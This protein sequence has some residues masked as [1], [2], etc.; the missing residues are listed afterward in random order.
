MAKSIIGDIVALGDGFGGTGT[1]TDPI[2]VDSSEINTSDLNNDAGFITGVTH[3]STITGDG[4]S[5]ASKLSV[6]EMVGSKVMTYAPAV[7][8]GVEYAGHKVGNQLWTGHIAY[9]TTNATWYKNDK[10]TYEAYG[11]Y[12]TF[13][14]VSIINSL[15]TD[16]W[17]VPTGNDINV[18]VNTVGSSNYKKLLSSADNGTD[19][20][21]LGWRL[22]GY[23]SSWM[24]SLARYRSSVSGDVGMIISGSLSYNDNNSGIS[25][26]NIV[27]VKDIVADTDGTKGLVPQPKIA[28]V[29]K[30]LRG[31]G[32]WSAVNVPSKT[33]DLTNDSGFIDSGDIT[34]ITSSQIDS[35]DWSTPVVL[36]PNTLRIQ[37]D[38]PADEWSM[39]GKDVMD[40]VVDAG[41]GSYTVVDE[42]KYIY[43]WTYNNSNWSYVFNGL[44]DYQAPGYKVIAAGDT[45]AVTNTVAMF[46]SGHLRSVCWM[47]LRNVTNMSSMFAKSSISCVLPDFDFDSAE[48][49]DE[50][51]SYVTSALGVVELYNKMSAATTI[52]SH[53]DT[54][55]MCG[56]TEEQAQIPVSWGGTKEEG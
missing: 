11:M 3:D 35:L 6:K 34:E 21:G 49:V 25:P 8:G 20:Y 39:S 46:S 38:A 50:M 23:D 27:L 22:G 55:E 24:G 26:T 32:T 31:D 5:D 47:D 19:D 56:S 7:L 1:A 51:F 18:L 4:S 37:W 54:F 12:Y 9:Q 43:D 36:P 10:S 53:E 14:D 15:L 48:S 44:V 40:M 16:G 33:S 30:Y 29:N 13:S 17:R 28:D 45:S 52:Q 42:S 2:S 41:K